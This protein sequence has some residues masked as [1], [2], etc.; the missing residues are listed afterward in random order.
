VPSPSL[1]CPVHAHQSSS[2]AVGA[3][4]SSTRGSTAPLPF[5]KRPRVRT[6]G[7]H[8]SHAVI[9]PSI[10]PAPAQLLARVSCAAAEPFLPRFAF[11]VAPCR[12]CAHG[13][14]RRDVLNVPGSF[15]KPP[16]PHHG[17][18]ARLR[19]TPAAVPSG[20]TAPKSTPCR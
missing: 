16:E 5:S 20:A 9:S 11:S 4:P 10:I 1:L 7:E 13:C 3:P 19:R 8:P 6:R 18:S 17:R 12:F 2:C 14:V 15:P